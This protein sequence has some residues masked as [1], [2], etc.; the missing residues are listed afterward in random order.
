M[1]EGIGFLVAVGCRIRL[2]PDPDSVE[3]YR[4]KKRGS[5]ILSH[6]QSRMMHSPVS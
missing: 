4:D 1:G 2:R 3:N 6:A 5:G